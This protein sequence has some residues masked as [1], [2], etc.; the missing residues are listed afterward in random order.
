MRRGRFN[1]ACTRSI[2]IWAVAVGSSV[3]LSNRWGSQSGGVPRPFIGVGAPVDEVPAGELRAGGVVRLED[4]QA[5]RV[6]KGL[7]SSSVACA[8]S[9][10]SRRC[11][12]GPGHAG[13]GWAGAALRQGRGLSCQA[14]GSQVP[15]SL[16]VKIAGCRRLCRWL[17][18][19]VATCTGVGCCRP[20]DGSTPD[21]LAS[22][23]SCFG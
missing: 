7:C 8:W 2:D 3:T 9:G 19:S 21:A 16:A 14:D 23:S 11:Q 20:D 4:L 22:P 15:G 6:E 13:G 12:C 18:C 17:A 1:R 10:W 5:Q